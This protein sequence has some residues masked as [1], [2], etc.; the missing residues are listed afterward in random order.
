MLFGVQYTAGGATDAAAL[1]RLKGGLLPRH[2][3]QAR[4]RHAVSW[5]FVTAIINTA[6]VTV[7]A[8]SAN[9]KFG[10]VSCVGLEARSLQ[11]SGQTVDNLSDAHFDPRS[12]DL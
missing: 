12:A 9:S 5:P 1:L 10:Q 3:G 2:R 11:R 4:P 8:R 6:S 7:D